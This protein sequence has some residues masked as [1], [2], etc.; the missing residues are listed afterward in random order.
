MTENQKKYLEK[1]GVEVE[2]E[3]IDLTKISPDELSENDKEF[4]NFIEADGG[5]VTEIYH[6]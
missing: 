1:L 3:I 5:I 4:L 2:V 6:F